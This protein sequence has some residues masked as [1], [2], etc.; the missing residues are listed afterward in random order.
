MS[1]LNIDHVGVTFKTDDGP[2]NVLD[3]VNLKVRKGE[4]VSL[5]GQSGCGKSTVL[6]VVAGLLEAT[7]GGVLLENR[8]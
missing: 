2:L 7:T 4:F 3:N 5:I 1:Y 8:R 6:N